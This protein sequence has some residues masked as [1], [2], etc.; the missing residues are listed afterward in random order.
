M[1]DGDY[2]CDDRDTSDE[3]T[4]PSAKKCLPNQSECESNVCIDTEKFCDGQYDCI[5]DEDPV[6]CRK[7]N[8]WFQRFFLYFIG[9]LI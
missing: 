6:N 8:L 3:D 9:I 1:C 5:N 7:Y 2:D 4:C